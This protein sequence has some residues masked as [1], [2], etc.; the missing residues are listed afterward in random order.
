MKFYTLLITLLLFCYNSRLSAQR[1]GIYIGY[2]SVDQIEDDDEKAAAQ[3]F[4]KTYGTNGVVITPSTLTRIAE[5]STLWIPIDRTGLTRG[6]QNLP[7]AYTNTEFINAIKQH[8]VDG[9][10]LYLTTH[11]TQLLKAIGRISST[12]APTIFGSGTGGNNPDTWGVNAEIGANPDLPNLYDHSSHSIYN[13]MTKDGSVYQ[14]HYF[15]PLIGSGWKEDHNCMWDFNAISTLTDNPNKVVDFEEKTTSSVLGTWQH[16]TDYACAG[17]IEFKPTG[18]FKGT[19]L[20]NGIAANEFNQ[21]DAPNVYQANMELLSH[22]SIDYLNFVAVK[23]PVVANTTA[24]LTVDGISSYWGT[25]YSDYAKT[26]PAGVTAYTV[27]TTGNGFAVLTKVASEG[28]VIPG[29]QGF[30]INTASAAEHLLFGDASEGSAPVVVDGNLLRGSE[31]A[32]SF[33]GEGTYYILGREQLAD[34]SYQYGLYWQQGTSGQRVDNEAHKAFLLVSTSSA[35]KS[36]TLTFSQSTAI[37]N[38]HPRS[39]LGQ[40][41][42]YNCSGQ[43]VGNNYKGV[44]IRDGKKYVAQ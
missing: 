38:V 32:Q 5:I 35:A 29:G 27:T 34:N 4:Q 23:R 7:S 6:W 13:G 16:V 11:A 8:V 36:L 30:F 40:G 1:A 24:Q 17:L 31:T 25:F 37:V 12:Y 22:N 21:N 41:V 39:I 14:D 44:V 15:F 19:V 9:G 42:V 3:W 28:D 20:A 26:V 10:S 18:E 2:E 33:S 43:R